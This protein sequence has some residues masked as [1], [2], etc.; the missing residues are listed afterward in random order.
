MVFKVIL[1][2]LPYTNLMFAPPINLPYLKAYAEQQDKDVSVKCL[3]LE[4]EFFESDVIQCDAAIYWRNALTCESQRDISPETC[5]ILEKFVD[6]IIAEKPDVVG[7]SVTNWNDRYTDF[8]S[9]KLR[10]LI[11]QIY[12]MYG[13]RQFCLKKV[14]RKTISQ[15]HAGEFPHIDCVVKNEGEAIFAE[16]I[17]SLERGIKPRFCAG[18]S[19]NVDSKIIDGVFVSGEIIDCG[20]RPHIRD[21][22]SIPFPD[23]SDYNK[24]A[25]LTDHIKI[26][27]SRGC[28]GVCEYCCDNDKMGEGVRIRSPENIITEIKL[29][30]QQ[31]YSK[32][33]ICDLCANTDVKKL[34]HICERIIA[35]KLDVEFIF[36]MFRHSPLMTPHSFELF[37]K[38]GLRLM[39]F[40][41]ESGSQEIL[42]R[43][44]KGIRVETIEKNFKDAYEAGLTNTTYLMAG[45]PGETE[46]TFQ[47]TI[48]L[49]IRNKKY[50]SAVGHIAEVNIHEGSLIQEHLDQYDLNRESLFHAPDVWM[51]ADGKNTLEWRRSLVEK[52]K[53]TM[54]QHQ[55]HFVVYSI[56][57]TPSYTFTKLI[58]ILITTRDKTNNF[59]MKKMLKKINLRGEY[60]AKLS[61]N[62]M[63]SDE[64]KCVINVKNVGTELWD[65]NKSQIFVG[66]RMYSGAQFDK[67]VGEWRS[68]LPKQIIEP[69]ESFTTEFFFRLTLKKGPY[70]LKFDVVNEHHFWFEDKGN[71]P[72]MVYV[73]A[74]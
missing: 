67:L 16:I 28:S 62:N 52:M 20:D 19:L 65:T 3:D 72:L 8:V 53:Q 47:K 4:K 35:E 74:V 23:F 48:D 63:L 18:T 15:R 50:I 58:P 6:M 11:P 7:F 1:T 37:R 66:C 32:F 41:T 44:H 70:L 43:M 49:I 22:D 21:L 59:N 36:A 9:H 29:R 30:K 60:L 13:G 14:W 10:L 46:E 25:Y 31:G 42:N 38:A 24:E 51:T 12:I 71:K 5:K 57:G 17:A 54:K 45:F 33:Q 34:E 69:Q 64:Y 61:L 68:D 73:D 27:F 2:M 26:I 55:I 39:T 56:D 40:G